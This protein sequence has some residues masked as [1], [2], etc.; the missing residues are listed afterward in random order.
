MTRE[1]YLNKLGSIPVNGDAASCAE[2]VYGGT[3]PAEVKQILSFSKESI[4]FDDGFRALSLAEVLG[5]WRELHVDFRA[6][7]LVPLFDCGE[8]DFIVYHIR[9]NVW[10]KY[11]IVDGTVFKKR[12][13]LE[14]LLA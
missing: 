3:L 5:A 11:N 6:Q 12:D 4:F 10:S 2:A 7:G 1:E 14:D 13:K 8:N 9:D